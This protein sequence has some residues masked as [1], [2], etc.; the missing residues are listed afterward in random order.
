[1][2]KHIH[3]EHDNIY[4]NT[5]YGIVYIECIQSNKEFVVSIFE[6]HKNASLYLSVSDRDDDKIAKGSKK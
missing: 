6:I 5:P 3:I 2:Q 4:I 1:M